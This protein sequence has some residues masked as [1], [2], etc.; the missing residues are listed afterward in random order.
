MASVDAHR[1]GVLAGVA[2]CWFANPF[3]EPL[4]FRTRLL[5]PAVLGVVTCVMLGIAA[6][7]A[8]GPARRAAAGN[9]VEIMRAQ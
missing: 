7:A 4:L 8:G 1:V 6:M 9:P 3:L 2:V 5:D